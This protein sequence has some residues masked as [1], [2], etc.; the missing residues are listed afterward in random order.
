MRRHGEL[1]GHRLPAD[2]LFGQRVF[3]RCVEGLLHAVGQALGQYHAVLP[4]AVVVL[5]RAD[6]PARAVEVDVQGLGDR[7]AADEAGDPGEVGA[8]DARSVVALRM[9]GVIAEH[10]DRPVSVPEREQRY[11]RVDDAFGLGAQLGVLGRGV[12]DRAD[13]AVRPEDAA[14]GRDFLHHGDAPAVVRGRLGGCESRFDRPGGALHHV[15]VETALEAA[16]VLQP[17]V[18]DQ[19]LGR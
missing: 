2:V 9:A 6:V 5:A 13:L 4:G 1:D 15:A 3:L 10:R 17:K 8:G 18:A 7:L 14:V 19:P 16:E 12:A 11:L